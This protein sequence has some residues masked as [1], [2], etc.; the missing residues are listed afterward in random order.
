MMVCQEVRKAQVFWQMERERIVFP[1]H[2]L[3]KLRL[4]LL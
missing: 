4:L 2:T 3:T 1:L